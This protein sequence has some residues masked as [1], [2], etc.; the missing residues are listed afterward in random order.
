VLKQVSFSEP[1]IPVYSN[2][3]GEPLE[4]ADQIAGMLQ[5]QLVEP[6]MWEKTMENLKGV[7]KNRLYEC[8]P[9]QQL[10]AM[11]KRIDL[12]MWKAMKNSTV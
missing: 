8:G 4:S 6:V 5:R 11:C 12:A 2:V 10:K 3:T 1:R 9:G 7:G